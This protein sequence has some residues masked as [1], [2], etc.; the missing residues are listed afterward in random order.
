MDAPR[1]PATQITTHRDGDQQV[2]TITRVNDDGS[3]DVATGTHRVLELTLADY[4][5]PSRSQ[6]GEIIWPRHK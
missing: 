2:T 6:P 4:V 3:Q 5:V 1:Q